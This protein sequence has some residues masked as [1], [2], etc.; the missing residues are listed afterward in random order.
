MTQDTTTLVA[1]ID[2]ANTAIA[3][4]GELAKAGTDRVGMTLVVTEAQWNS[5]GTALTNARFNWPKGFTTDCMIGNRRIEVGYHGTM[6]SDNRFTRPKG[7]KVKATFVI[8]VMTGVGNRSVVE[9]VL[10]RSGADDQ[11]EHSICVT[12]IAR[13]LLKGQSICPADTEAIAGDQ[14]PSLTVAWPFAVALTLFKASGLNCRTYRALLELVLAGVQKPRSKR[15]QAASDSFLGPV[16]YAVAKIEKDRGVSRERAVSELVNDLGHFCTE[17]LVEFLEAVEEGVEAWAEQKGWGTQTIARIRLSK[18][19]SQHQFIREVERHRDFLPV[20]I[21]VANGNR[22]LAETLKR[23][24]SVGKIDTLVIDELS[25]RNA[26]DRAIRQAKLYFVL[27]TADD[28]AGHST[29]A[30]ALMKAWIRKKE[31]RVISTSPH[32]EWDQAWASMGLSHKEYVAISH[33]YKIDA[34]RS[35]TLDRFIAKLTLPRVKRP[36]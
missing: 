15:I 13:E 9:V 28:F 11:K 18:E 17:E 7:I 32:A 26:V 20:C 3:E 24:L 31:I 16:S 12:G 4:T 35:E 29:L 8:D 10:G 34:G 1:D 21:V 27:G 33:N 14:G 25:S 5:V 6:K 36:A 19:K 22:H 2:D 30:G 23:H